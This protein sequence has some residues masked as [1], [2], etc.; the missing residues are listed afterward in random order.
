MPTNKI[1]KPS[2]KAAKAASGRAPLDPKLAY[3]HFLP[4]AMAL[5]LKEVPVARVSAAIAR[6]N[7]EKAHRAISPR[8]SELRQIAPTLDP[9]CLADLPALAYAFEYA[10]KLVPK[11]QS[12]GSIDA[13]LA[14]VSPIRQAALAYLEAASFC[15]LVDAGRVRAIREGTGKLDMASDAVTIAGLFEQAKGQLAGRHPFSQEQLTILRERG[16]WLLNRLKPSGA[17]RDPKSRSPEALVK[18]RFAK[19][20]EDDYAT[21]LKAA[22]ALWGIDGYRAQIPALHASGRRRSAKG[23]KAAPAP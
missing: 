14:Q 16:N 9:T 4:R 8:L 12:D 2:A 10:E 19:L 18:D 6:V 21:L 22:V 7:V 13:A 1:A 11:D 15:G 3:E 23:P 17:V 5:P 20:L